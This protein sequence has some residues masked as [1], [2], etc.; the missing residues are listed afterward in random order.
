MRRSVALAFLIAAVS[1]PA[2]SAQKHPQLPDG[3]TTR[4]CL[5]C[6]GDHVRGEVV[7]GATVQCGSCHQVLAEGSDTSIQLTKK[8]SD[9]CFS[10]H[11]KSEQATVHGPYRS[12]AC[13]D[14]HDPHAAEQPRLLR[15]K[16]STLCSGCH[17]VDFRGTKIDYAAKTVTLPWKKTLAKSAYDAAPKIELDDGGITGHPVPVHPVSGQNSRGTGQITCL[18]CHR[19][20]T[21]DKASL[22]RTAEKGSSICTSC[23]PGMGS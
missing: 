12:G 19:H 23:H 6:H 10:C 8:G 2:S 17:I 21:S 22:V 4:G 7:H 18:T 15:A 9:L 11:K 1:L 14:C 20:H 5:Q 16:A 13:I 3:V